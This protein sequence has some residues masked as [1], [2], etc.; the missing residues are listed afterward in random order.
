[1]LSTW[2]NLYMTTGKEK[3]LWMEENLTW[4]NSETCVLFCFALVSIHWIALFLSKDAWWVVAL[5]LFICFN[6]FNFSG[7]TCK[8]WSRSSNILLNFVFS[9]RALKKRL[10]LDFLQRNPIV[11]HS[12]VYQMWSFVRGVCVCV[13]VCGSLSA[14]VSVCM[15]EKLKLYDRWLEFVKL[16]I[17]VYWRYYKKFTFY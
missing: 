9:Q 2:R 16:D 5:T 4:V 10:L 15:E 17:G 11:G 12:L 8:F 7:W 1:M 3:S 14:S 6:K 13:C